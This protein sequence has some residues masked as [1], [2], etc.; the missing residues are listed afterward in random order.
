MIESLN[1]WLKAL[2]IIFM[3]MWF[4]GL[5]YLPRLYVYHVQANVQNDLTGSQRFKVMERK[6]FAIMTVGGVGAVVLGLWLLARYVSNGSGWLSQNTWMQVKLLIVVLLIFFHGACWVWM[7]R[8]SQDQNRHS[9]R[10]YRL[11]NEVPAVVLISVVIL[12]IVKP[13]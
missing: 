7:K 5:F 12:A 3:V 1:L 9:E 8:F 6:L 2:H 11:W 10:F 4:A 13:F